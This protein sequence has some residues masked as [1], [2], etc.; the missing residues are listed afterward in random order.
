MSEINLNERFPDLRPLNGPPS[1]GMVNGIGLTVYGR[2]DHDPV[3]DTYVKTRYFCVLFIPVLALGAY[4]VL[5]AVGGGWYFLGRV[6][7]SGLAK[8]FN[9]LIALLV[10]G[11]LGFGGWALY[12]S[13]E[14]YREGQQLAEA[15][16]LAER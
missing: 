10:V 5:D 15:D 7:M 6:P 3:T 11:G 1:L 8:L 4:R 14:S 9:T 13:T 2:R 16:R 12:T